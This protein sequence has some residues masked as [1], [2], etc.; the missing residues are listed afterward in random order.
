MDEK[1]TTGRVTGVPVTIC[2][3]CRVLVTQIL[4]RSPFGWNHKPAEK[5]ADFL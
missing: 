1:R 4:T 5:Q 2:N 3:S